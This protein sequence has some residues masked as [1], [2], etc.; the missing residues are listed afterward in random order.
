MPV[1]IRIDKNGINQHMTSKDSDSFALVLQNVREDDNVA[2]NDKDDSSDEIEYPIKYNCNQI[3]TKINNWING[4]NEKVTHFQKRLSINSNSYG[5]FMALKGP[6]SGSDNQTLSAAH[7]W[8]C[9][10]EAKGL[11]IPA[12]KKASASEAQK[13]D[14]SK[15]PKLDDEDAGE[16]R[17]Y[18]TCADLRTQIRAHLRQP[19]V[20]QASFAREISK[21]VGD[22]GSPIQ[23]VQ[24]ASFLKKK[25]IMAGNT[26]GAFYA[27]YV[28]FERMR[29]RDGKSKSKKRQE[30]EARWG[31][32][33]GVDLRHVSE[34]QHY[35]RSANAPPPTINQYGQVG[36]F[37]I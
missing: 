19:G 16:V 28:Y 7:Q 3:R 11:K 5:R 31:W 12:P 6:W 33:G 30:M 20:T 4:G 9:E 1:V 14:A 34:N 27:S 17:I 25:D 22:Q 8:F 15:M 18:A 29:L 32:Q 2:D 37:S 10:R 36:K 35:I 24:V 26:S 23:G 13:W 21:C